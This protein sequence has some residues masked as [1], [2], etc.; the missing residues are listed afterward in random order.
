MSSVSGSSS[1]KLKFLEYSLYGTL[2][3]FMIP[4]LITIFMVPFF[5]IKSL[6]AY[7]NTTISCD[8][9]KYLDTKIK[10]TRGF[11]VA[12]IVLVFLLGLVFIVSR[13]KNIL[14]GLT[15]T[16]FWGYLL[17]MLT[18]L[19]IFIAIVALA[20]NP[21][22][23]SECGKV[24]AFEVLSKTDGTYNNFSGSNGYG[25]QVTVSGEALTIDKP[26]S[27]YKVGDLIQSGGLV[28]RITEVV[29]V[30]GAPTISSS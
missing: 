16:V 29:G 9:A 30:V 7:A 8:K 22:D 15:T 10:I 2:F 13:F 26:G 28:I 3:L 20:D 23:V 19:G 11:Y 1:S 12:M 17:I 24:V 5:Y 27:G 25:L 18:L 6:A 21:L 14:S 4:F